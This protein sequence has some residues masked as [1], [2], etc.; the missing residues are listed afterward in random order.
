MKRPKLTASSFIFFAGMTLVVNEF[1]MS[2]NFSLNF[3]LNC[4]TSASIFILF[5]SKCVAQSPGYTV[6][7]LIKGDQPYEISMSEWMFITFGL[8]FEASN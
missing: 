8:Y 4:R 5:F 6:F 1:A 3:I 2:G 7:F